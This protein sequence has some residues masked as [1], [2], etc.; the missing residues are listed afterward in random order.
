MHQRVLY[1]RYDRGFGT[2]VGPRERDPPPRRTEGWCFRMQLADYVGHSLA[3]Q[4]TRARRR[5]LPLSSEQRREAK[6]GEAQHGFHG[7]HNLS[8]VIAA[9]TFGVTGLA[10]C[11]STSLGAQSAI[12]RG[13]ELVWGGDAEGGAPFVEADPANPSRV[14]GFDVE[15]AERIAYGLGGDRMARFVQVQWS[16]IDLSVERGDFVLGLSGVEDTPARRSRHAVTLPYFEF[17]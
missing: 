12:R 1:G 17:R 4:H 8:A 11:L 2:L 6:D 10:L 14:R 15:V 3:H 7:G 9:R 13:G 16:D 5:E